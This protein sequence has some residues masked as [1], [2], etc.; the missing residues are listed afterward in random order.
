M[1]SSLF[2][3]RFRGLSLIGSG[4]TADVYRVEDLQHD[5]RAFAL[6]HLVRNPRGDRARAPEFRLLATLNHPNLARVCDFGRAS[7]GHAWFTM[8][9]VQGRPIDQVAR[10]LPLAG[11]L[12]L[13]VG[14]LRALRHIH[15]RGFVHFDVKPSN[16]LVEEHRDREP[17]VKV[18]DLGLAGPIG[19]GRTSH[20]RGSV[21][22]VAPE[23]IRGGVAD[24]RADLYSLGA[25]LY[26]AIV[27]RPPF[28]GPGPAAVL[29]AHLETRPA[30]P[31][32]A[33]DLPGPLR[34]LVLRMLSKDPTMRP[35]GALAA[36]IEIAGIGERDAEAE[37]D[38]S[39]HLHEPVYLWRDEPRH[40]IGARLGAIAERE[41]AGPILVTGTPGVGKSSLL[42]EIASDAS[43]MGLRVFLAT[44]R[45]G[46][47]SPH[48]LFVAAFRDR[49]STAFGPL[50]GEGSVG[51]EVEQEMA[52]IADHERYGSKAPR[53]LHERLAR[54][55]RRIA[56]QAPTALVLQNLD[57]AD[58]E[59]IDLV[60]H[61]IEAT[62][63]SAIVLV[64][65]VN[66]PDD[67]PALWSSAAGRKGPA[68][69]LHIPLRPFDRTETLAF[70]GEMIAVE[71]EQVPARFADS[72]LEATDGL[73]LFVRESVRN[74]AAE[75]SGPWPEGLFRS[76]V[77]RL[78]ASLEAVVL[79]RLGRIPPRTRKLLRFMSVL[80]APLS[81]AEIG[82]ATDSDQSAEDL[83]LLAA[84]G[85]VRQTGEGLAI[86]SGA[87]RSTLY[88]RTRPSERRQFH[89]RVARILEPAL[90]SDGP[91]GD[92]A[93]HA[94]RGGML[95][96]AVRASLRAAEQ[97]LQAHAPGRAAEQIEAV[98]AELD[99]ERPAERRRALALLA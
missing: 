65:S 80:N 85:L 45:S 84:A 32:T 17:R 93:H 38:P 88:R 2:G 5:G 21:G 20:A 53:Q 3:D 71:P 31:D 68:G 1:I 34:D 99:E 86:R 95:D 66:S 41:A 48:G 69:F 91:I 76:N 83:V 27:G 6:K 67:A 19:A 33:E 26:E 28:A 30:F 46:D 54:F 44:A 59:T 24:E 78:P 72:L 87:I 62:A 70:L 15:A 12:R 29:R 61:L 60:A 13:F 10:D 35:S 55:L 8:D 4:A 37:T 11:L 97:S 22:Y 23:L 51:P 73:P 39:L 47:L 42:R 56:E 9:L 16:L 57:R 77:A 81:A 75:M 74:A 43:L 7:D 25:V 64:A 94:L 79:A 89:A 50:S 58:A 18:V 96:L 98:W 14:A 52:R 49:R 36:L 82:A 63:E 40:E 90:D 92:L